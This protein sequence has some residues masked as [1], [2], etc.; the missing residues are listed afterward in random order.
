MTWFNKKR[1]VASKRFAP[2]KSMLEK[3][4]SQKLPRARWKYEPERIEYMLPKRYIPDFVIA[5]KSGKK[6]YLEVKG[7]MRWEDQQ[8]MRAVKNSRPEMDI[9]F[10]FANDNKVQ[11]SEMTNSEWCEKYDFPCAI[12]VLPASWWRE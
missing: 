4:V 8:K 10:Y 5:T 9:R 12:G 2:F 1:K 7:W 3:S 11:T 6:I